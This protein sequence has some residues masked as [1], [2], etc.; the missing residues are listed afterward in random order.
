[1]ESAITNSQSIHAQKKKTIEWN[2]SIEMVNSKQR[3]ARESVIEREDW[4]H[5]KTWMFGE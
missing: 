4:Q 5:L 1:M 3:V 2:A